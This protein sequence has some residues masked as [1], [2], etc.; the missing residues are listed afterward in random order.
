MILHLSVHLSN[1]RL[2]GQ[3]TGAPF[4]SHLILA[5]RPQPATKSNRNTC[6]VNCELN[7]NNPC[8]C[9]CVPQCS[10][11]A[12]L[13]RRLPEGVTPSTKVSLSV[14]WRWETVSP[15]APATTRT[16]TRYTPSAGRWR[17]KRNF[18]LG[19]K[20]SK[21][22]QRVPLEHEKCYDTSAVGSFSTVGQWLA[23]LP[24]NQGVGGSIPALVDVSLSKTLNPAL[25]CVAVS[26]VYE[27]NMNVSCCGYKRQLK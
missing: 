8:V 21:R 17:L 20:V 23:G 2:H 24:L 15:T 19:W 3:L 18:S 5:R 12:L 9:V 11:R 13:P 22:Q 16:R 1:K 10:A 27:W 26:T 25:L 7:L 14:W 4:S 6:I